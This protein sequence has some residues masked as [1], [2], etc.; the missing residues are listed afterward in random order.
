MSTDII[1]DNQTAAAISKLR[2][3]EATDSL[4]DEVSAALLTA[5]QTILT[6]ISEMKQRLWT[7]SQLRSLIDERHTSLCSGCPTRQWVEARKAADQVAATKMTVKQE[8]D[9]KG[10]WFRELI[11]S[12]G[13]RYFVLVVLLI[14]AVIYVKTGVDGVAAIERA[15]VHTI[16]GGAG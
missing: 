4:R 3:G 16:T 12:E 2:R 5:I 13:T 8:D 7:P 15:A 10:G 1:A 9:K 6:D 14:W 11:R